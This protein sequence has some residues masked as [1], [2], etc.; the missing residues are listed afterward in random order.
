MSAKNKETIRRI[1]EESGANLDMLDGLFTDD[2]V[3]H[4]PSVP[5]EL[6][7][8]NAFKEMVRGFVQAMPDARE[9]VEQQL[10]DGDKVFT[11]FSGRGTQTGELMG[12]PASGKEITWTGMVVF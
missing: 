3:Y 12:V 11:R 5:G 2:Y 7:G 9:K 8:A 1:R 10:A 6:H 4:G